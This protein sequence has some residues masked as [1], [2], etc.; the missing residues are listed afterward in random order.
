MQSQ[1]GERLRQMGRAGEAERV[2][3]MCWRGW[4][5]RRVTNEQ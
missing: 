1:Q 3:E 4:V 2:F 5:M